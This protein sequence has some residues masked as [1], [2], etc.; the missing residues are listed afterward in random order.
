MREK[1]LE[2]INLHYEGA[3]LI[4]HINANSVKNRYE[5]GS[6]MFVYFLIRGNEIVYIGQ[7]I[8]I[9]KRLNDHK[10]DKSFGSIYLIEIIEWLDSSLIENLA[11]S[12]FNPRHNCGNCNKSVS[13]IVCKHIENLML[14]NV[15]CN[16][17]ARGL[18]PKMKKKYGIVYTGY[19]SNLKAA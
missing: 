10:R 7:S 4:H 19:I 15:D 12:H 11:I 17:Y 2:F 3:K 16:I 8:N 13:D 5:D 6:R 18:L 14:C 9:H 1:I